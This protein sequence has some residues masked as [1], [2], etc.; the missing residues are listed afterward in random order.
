MSAVLLVVVAII[1]SGAVLT[2]RKRSSALASTT[3]D[4]SGLGSKTASTANLK[5]LAP[6]PN[7]PSVRILYG[8]QVSSSQ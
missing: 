2:L 1:F 4:K 3:P 5:A 6:D 7:K 8:T